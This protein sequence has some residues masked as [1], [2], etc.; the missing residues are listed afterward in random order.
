[1]LHVGITLEY[2]KK[3]LK[4]FTEYRKAAFSSLINIF[5]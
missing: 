5:S 4:H 3:I 1:M 2:E